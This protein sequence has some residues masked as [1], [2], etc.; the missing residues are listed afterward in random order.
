MADNGCLGYG[1]PVTKPL[2]GL[3]RI[4]Y[5]NCP[6]MEGPRASRRIDYLRHDWNPIGA[7]P[8]GSGGSLMPKSYNIRPSFNVSGKPILNLYGQAVSKR[9]S[10]CLR[11]IL[12]LDKRPRAPKQ[13]IKGTRSQSPCL[14]C[15]MRQRCNL[16]SP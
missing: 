15:S 1:R 5:Y 14:Y 7:P 2:K 13:R 9:L 16:H 4:Q 8:L 12:N 6:D 3:H 11:A 10:R